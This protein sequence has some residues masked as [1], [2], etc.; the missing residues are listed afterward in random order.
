MNN[1]LTL[2]NGKECTSFGNQKNSN[3]LILSVVNLQGQS[4]GWLICTYLPVKKFNVLL[5]KYSD[6]K[7]MDAMHPKLNNNPNFSLHL[8]THN[9]Y[10]KFIT[11]GRQSKIM[12]NFKTIRINLPKKICNKLLSIW[13]TKK[14]ITS[15]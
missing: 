2:I 1:N 9:N 8:T 13:V 15:C 5:I 12:T 3:D 11:N 10:K 4:L 6:K 14:E 7:F